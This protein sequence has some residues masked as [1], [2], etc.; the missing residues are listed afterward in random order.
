M[1]LGNVRS[2]SEKVGAAGTKT[3]TFFVG[4]FVEMESPAFISAV[5][6]M[7]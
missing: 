1:L 5:I 7:I 6:P 4:T 2:I 3:G